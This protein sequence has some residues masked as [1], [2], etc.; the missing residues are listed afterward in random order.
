MKIQNK[1]KPHVN[2]GVIGHFHTSDHLF[3][4]AILACIGHSK[5]GDVILVV[6]EDTTNEQLK[7]LIRDCAHLHSLVVTPISTPPEMGSIKESLAGIL[8]SMQ[9]PPAPVPAH[10][11][12]PWPPLKKRMPY[13][14]HPGHKHRV[15]IHLIRSHRKLMH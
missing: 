6:P 3:V 5:R 13:E 11:G 1:G 2:V 7:E 9:R 4:S 12:T 15:G 14:F 10:Q 8:E